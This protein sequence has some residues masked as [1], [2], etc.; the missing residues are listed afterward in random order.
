[1][2]STTP[3]FNDV[4]ADRILGAKRYKVEVKRNKRV[5][6]FTVS[7]YQSLVPLA[8]CVLFMYLVGFLPGK[9]DDGDGDSDNEFELIHEALLVNTVASGVLFFAL[10]L[11]LPVAKGVDRVLKYSII[12]S[13]SA[14]LFQLVEG[15]RSAGE[16]IIQPPR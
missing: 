12:D 11:G 1:M 7:M 10:G 15:L 5:L 16:F 3:A 6:K 2:L 14:F 9:G 13:Y 4:L 8:P